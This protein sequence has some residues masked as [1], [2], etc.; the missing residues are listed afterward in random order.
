MA[1]LSISLSSSTEA[2]TYDLTLVAMAAEGTSDWCTSQQPLGEV[3]FPKTIKND[4]EP[5]QNPIP[6]KIMFASS[7]ISSCY[8]FQHFVLLFLSLHLFCKTWVTLISYF[9]LQHFPLCLFEGPNCSCMPNCYLSVEDPNSDLSLVL[10]SLSSITGIIWLI[11][12]NLCI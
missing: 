9:S 5:A 4:F 1:S 6:N 2:F 7:A 8:P 3:I 12:T 10:I 11:I